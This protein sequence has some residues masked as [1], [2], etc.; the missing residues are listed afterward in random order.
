MTAI[1]AID[2]H[3]HALLPDL[4]PNLGPHERFRPRFEVHGGAERIVVD[5]K[6]LPPDVDPRLHRVEARLA[7]LEREEG[8]VQVVS[9]PPFSFLYDL[10]PKAGRALAAAQNDSIARLV[11]GHPGAFVALG[12]LP[13]QSVPMALEEMDRCIKDL[14]MKGVEVGSNVDGRDLDAPEFR[15]LFRRAQELSIPILLHAHARPAYWL[16]L[17]DY[18]LAN[19]L[20]YPMETTIAIAR[21]ILGGVCRDFPRLRFITIHGGGF[22]PYQMGRL[23]R[24]HRTRGEA[25]GEGVEA[26]EAYLDSFLFDSLVHDTQALEFLVRRV[27]HRRVVLGSDYPFPMGDEGA[28]EKVA[29]LAVPKEEREAILWGNAKR[30]L[31][32]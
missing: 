22:F 32:I 20:G 6:V 8:L 1:S 31:R 19:P 11:E 9:P 23:T 28:R 26:P 3:T 7:D 15:P 18:Y 25:R 4:F 16:V 12:T 24:V 13:L 21:L 2:V 27:G 29:K 10:E 5:G 17:K 30:L 14:G